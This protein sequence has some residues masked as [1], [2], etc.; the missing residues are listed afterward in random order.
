M[1]LKNRCRTRH[2]LLISQIAISRRIPAMTTLPPK[3]PHPAGRYPGSMPTNSFGAASS[4]RAG[5]ADYRIFRLRSL[6]EQGV[7]N[8]ER[9]PFA[10]KILLENLLRQEDG[11]RVSAGDI[12]YVA[13]G[14]D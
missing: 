3:Q 5:N 7:G 10:T 12:E 4:L 8:I 13:A 14:A 2:N 6:A 11:R 9:L 1:A